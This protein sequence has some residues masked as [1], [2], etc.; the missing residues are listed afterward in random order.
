MIQNLIFR[1]LFFF[2][3]NIISV[4]GIQL[5][6]ILPHVSVEIIRVFLFFWF[7]SR[8][9]QSQQKLAKKIT[10]FTILFRSKNLTHFKKLNS[11]DIENNILSQRSQKPFS[12]DKFSSQQFSV[13][14]QKKYLHCIISWRP[15]TAFLKYLE[16]KCLYIS[17]HPCKKIFVPKILSGLERQND[18]LK[19]GSLFEPRKVFYNFSF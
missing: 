5:F 2:F 8:K 14:F 6:C 17:V 3:L 10:H 19:G 9:P 7:S 12:L 15:R 11:L 16:S 18:F 1:I 13:W 4:S